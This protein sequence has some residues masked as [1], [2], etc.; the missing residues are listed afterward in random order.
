MHTDVSPTQEPGTAER[1][2]RTV[3]GMPGTQIV[4]E[5]AA[6]QALIGH[7]RGWCHNST[8]C[9]LCAALNEQANARVMAERQHAHAR[10]QELRA[11]DAQVDVAY[12]TRALAAMEARATKAESTLDSIIS[13]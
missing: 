6:E 3:Y 4:A 13:G 9:A 12:L 10:T 2:R 8:V 5:D 7:T 11:I 1:H